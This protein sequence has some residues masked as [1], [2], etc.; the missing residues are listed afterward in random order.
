VEEAVRQGRLMSDTRGGGK[1][2]GVLGKWALKERR[3][4]SAAA[5]KKAAP[6]RLVC[7]LGLDLLLLLHGG[8]FACTRLEEWRRGVRVLVCQSLPHLRHR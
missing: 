3:Y 5:R 7:V 6:L 8:L 1:T 2:D 4:G